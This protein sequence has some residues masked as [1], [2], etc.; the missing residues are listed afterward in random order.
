MFGGMICMSVH[1]VHISVDEIEYKKLLKAKGTKT[2]HDLVM[3]V[4]K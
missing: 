3:E 2:W 4:A 1:N